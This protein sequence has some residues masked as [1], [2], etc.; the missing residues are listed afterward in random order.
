M[1]V[2]KLA[3]EI[4]AMQEEIEFL[5]AEVEELRPYKKKYWDEIKRGTE[6]S[7]HMLGSILQ[8]AL[9]PGVCEAIE[10]ARTAGGQ[11]NEQ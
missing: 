6:H 11:E 3:H 8:L 5:R 1:S 2:V 9:V 7:Q 10:N 4:L